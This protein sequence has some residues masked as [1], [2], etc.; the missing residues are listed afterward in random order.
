MKK[1]TLA[2]AMLALGA[3]AQT[4]P[5]PYCEIAEPVNP[6]GVEEISTVS[7]AGISITNTESSSILIDRT[8]TIVNLAPDETYSI[9]ITGNTYG[10]Y[11]S[12]IVAFIDWNQNDILDDAGEVYELGLLSD[13][14]GT[15]GVSVTLDI[16]VPTDAVLGETRIR[17]TKTYTDQGTDINPPSTAI[18]DPCGI[19]FNAFGVERQESFGQALDFTLNLATLS[20]DEFELN[21]LAVYPNPAQDVLNID[22][23]SEL[24]GVKIYNLLGQEVLNRTAATS[25]MKLDI[26]GLTSGVYI[27][28][29]S[30]EEGE[31][32]FRVVKE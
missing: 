31:H 29:L 17:I 21:A 3:Q 14:N 10:A 2:I 12:N 1:I 8:A 28:K 32:S 20:V 23:K 11:D 30:A 6:F 15:D 16:T 5:S 27:V 24:T 19:V 18:V 22:Y 26:S 4:F 25:Q 13:T 9:V 7:F